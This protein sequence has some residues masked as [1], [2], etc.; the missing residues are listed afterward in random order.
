MKP[1]RH[2]LPVLPLFIAAAIAQPA[3]AQPE[4]QVIRKNERR[5]PEAE[6]EVIR[7]R[8]VMRELGADREVEKE[9]VTFL[10]VETAPVGRTVA[11]Q[12]G[13]DRDIGLVVTRVQK[14][15][16][17]AETLKE[18]D[19]LL[20]FEDQLLID[21]RQF[22]VLIRAKKPGDR[23]TL[24]LLRAGK[25]QKVTVTLGEREMPKIFGFREFDFGPGDG[26][27]F[28]F[29][30][31]D[32]PAIARLRELP[33]LAREELGD[34]FRMLGDE[35]GNWFKS[36]RVHVLNRDMGSTILNLNE[37]NFVF[38]DDEGSVEVN[39]ND[40]KRQLTV[41]DASGKV[42]YEGAINSDED[43][44]KLPP[45]VKERLG[46]IEGIDIDVEIGADFKQEGA[47]IEKPSKAKI[48]TKIPARVKPTANPRTL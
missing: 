39:A 13:L 19:I 37:G 6:R 38:S 47:A 2:L 44:K 46:K 9:K 34:V 22:S 48:G 31:G 16:A 15:S 33:G 20:K 4:K 3:F 23:V 28:R 26:Q 11:A 29:F 21:A 5:A 42:T 40:G 24:T 10:G 8:K 45:E 35:K 14:D 32:S 1:I 18:H 25:E 41:K 17:A 43:R 27:G 30:N 12:L 7:E 36:P